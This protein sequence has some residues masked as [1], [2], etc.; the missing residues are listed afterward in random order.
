MENSVQA[1]LTS[2]EKSNKRLKF[3]LSALL[4]GAA[5]TV[6]LAAGAPA[7][8]IVTAE[9]FVLRDASGK[10][11]AEL[12]ANKQSVALQLLN[13]NGS[14]GLALVAGVAGNGIFI[15]DL[16]GN[17]R[18]AMLASD[19]G[20]AV[21]SIIKA[22]SKKDA[23]IVKDLQKATVLAF[24]DNQG[25]DRIDLGYFE[26]G[27]GMVVNDANSTIRSMVGEPGMATYKADGKIEWASAGDDM[28]LRERQ[29]IKD[30]FN[31]TLK[32]Q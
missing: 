11:R 8:R 32:P 6:L 18:E 22:E 20:T 3:L 16:K 9:R 4:L 23:F 28:S 25:T 29:Q 21:L 30:L 14:K 27:A 12:A 7:P 2:L 19:D 15:S 10:E 24:N 26:K 13:D 17:D 31:S 5:A 1:R